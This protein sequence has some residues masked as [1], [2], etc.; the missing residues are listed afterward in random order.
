[1]I[2]NLPFQVI[3]YLLFSL[4]DLVEE[5]VWVNHWPGERFHAVETSISAHSNIRMEMVL[6]LSTLIQR[7]VLSVPEGCKLPSGQLSGDGLLRQPE[8]Y[9]LALNRRTEVLDDFGNPCSPV[10]SRELCPKLTQ[11]TAST[12]CR[13]TTKWARS[14]WGHF[15]PALN[16]QKQFL[17]CENCLLLNIE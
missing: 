6:L 1:M 17:D 10:E 5:C 12:F 2:N 11:T 7:F 8:Q 3:L 14:I 9:R 16:T 4:L 15:F 13:N